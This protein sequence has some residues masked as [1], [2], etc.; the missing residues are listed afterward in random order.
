MATRLTD[1]AQMIPGG[2]ALEPIGGSSAVASGPYCGNRGA[3]E[4]S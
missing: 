3:V 2:T 4:G 1:M